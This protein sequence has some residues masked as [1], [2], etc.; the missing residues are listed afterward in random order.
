MLVRGHSSAPVYWNRPDKTAETMRG[1]WI[2]TGDRFVE[3]DGY[4]YFQG[5]ADDLIKVSGQWVWPLEVERCLN[6]HGAVQE[7]AVHALELPDKRMS[8]RAVVA[9]RAG[10]HPDD[11]MTRALQDFVKTRLQPHKYPRVVDYVD[12]L[13]KTGTGKIDRRAVSGA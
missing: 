2:Y 5:R 10:A 9:L 4:Y 12:T 6:E 11:E 7:C 8:L 1:D 3:R 13:P